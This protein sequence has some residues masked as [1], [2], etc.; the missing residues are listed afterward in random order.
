MNFAKFLKEKKA[1]L[2]V[3]TIVVIIFG[4]IF[5]LFVMKGGEFTVEA[6]SYT[7]SSSNI[8][9]KGSNTPRLLPGQSPGE[10][11]NEDTNPVPP[12]TFQENNGNFESKIIKR[13]NVSINV[14]QEKFL[15]TFNE[16]Q[17]FAKTSGGYVKSSSYS[18]Y[19]DKMS[20]VIDLMVPS[21]KLEDFLNSVKKFGRIESMNISSEDVSGEYVDLNSRL[22]VLK[23][24]EDLLLSWLSRAKNI[25]EMLQI[26][27]QLEQV[28]TQIET[29][30][31]RMKYIN[32]HTSYSEVY[33]NLNHESNSPSMLGSYFNGLMKRAGMGIVYSF[34]FLLILLAWLIPY[35]I[36]V[37]IV[38]LIWKKR[39]ES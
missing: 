15:D 2:V 28:Q 25:S 4:A 13:A 20:G 34:G 38:Y 11:V 23:S 32:F 30:K 5:G 6:P 9:Q 27:T 10:N 26:R 33:I 12:E 37:F 19:K 1:I 3:L 35:L 21:D 22:N 14:S 29:I 18:S 31:G 8:V 17:V 16:I 36:I 24:Q 39:K 7:D